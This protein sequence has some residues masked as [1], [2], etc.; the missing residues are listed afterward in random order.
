MRKGQQGFLQRGRE[1]RGWGTGLG[2]S[3]LSLLNV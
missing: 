1:I 3:Y 2:D